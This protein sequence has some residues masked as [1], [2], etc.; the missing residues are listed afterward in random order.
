MFLFLIPCLLLART[1]HVNCDRS[2]VNERVQLFPATSR[3]QSAGIMIL[4]SIL[5]ASL[6]T[7]WRPATTFAGGLDTSDRNRD[8]DRD[9][10]SRT[11]TCFSFTEDKQPATKRRGHSPPTARRN[12]EQKRSENARLEDLSIK[13]IHFDTNYRVA[14]Q[15]LHKSGEPGKRQPTA[16]KRLF[17]GCVE[18]QS[19]PEK[20]IT[21][22]GYYHYHYTRTHTARAGNPFADWPDHC[23]REYACVFSRKWGKAALFSPQIHSFSP[24]ITTDSALRNRTSFLSSTDRR[25]NRSENLVENRSLTVHTQQEGAM[26]PKSRNPVNRTV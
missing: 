14:L 15:S 6:N 26:P 9:F 22:W 18:C 4:F 20:P 13:S 10:R 17:S 11:D 24:D 5:P 19:I 3:R 2:A 23:L 16:V 12:G 7:H 21:P 8:R 1:S 25:G